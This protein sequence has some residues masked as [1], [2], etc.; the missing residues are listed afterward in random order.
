[1]ASRGTASLR[2]GGAQRRPT[3]PALSSARGSHF[4]IRT[5]LREP[6]P[7]SARRG[8]KGRGGTA[9][10]G[11]S[12]V[13]CWEGSLTTAC[14]GPWAPQDRRS[15]PGRPWRRPGPPSATGFARKLGVPGVS[16]THSKAAV[17]CLAPFLLGVPSPL[18]GTRS[19][20]VL[21]RNLSCEALGSCFWV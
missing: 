20:W 7:S 15:T 8:W 1:M 16:P 13:A 2:V 3:G 19:L 21:R 11:E 9:T 4:Q 17:A 6:R 5:W 12:G 10:S 18:A 14:L